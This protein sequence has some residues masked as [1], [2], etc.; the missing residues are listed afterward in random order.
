MRPFPIS[1]RIHPLTRRSRTQ[2][3]EPQTQ[4]RYCDQPTLRNRRRET[5]T[6]SVLSRWRPTPSPFQINIY[7]ALCSVTS[8]QTDSALPEDRQTSKQHL[9]LE[10]PLRS[11]ETHFP[12]SPKQSVEELAI[13][14]QKSFNA[15][16]AKWTMRRQ[17]IS[18][19][20]R[21]WVYN[22]KNAF[23]QLWL[24]VNA[25]WGAKTIQM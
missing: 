11:Q 14:V 6:N 2:L 10:N 25:K 9:T 3:T 24:Q 23:A 1:R 7:S 13:F 20:Y 22:S 19:Q 4:S 15:Y 16:L 5:A 18:V 12:M 21:T 17:G 8:V